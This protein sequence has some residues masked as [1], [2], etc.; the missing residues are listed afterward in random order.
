[1]RLERVSGHPLGKPTGWIEC[2][3]CVPF[4]P[5]SCPALSLATEQSGT[6]EKGSAAVIPSSCVCSPPS[7]AWPVQS[8]PMATGHH[9]PLTLQSS[10]AS[11][12]PSGSTG[13]EP[14]MAG[15]SSPCMLTWGKALWGAGMSLEKSKGAFL[16]LQGGILE[17]EK[18]LSAGTHSGQAA[19]SPGQDFCAGLGKGISWM[20]HLDHLKNHCQRY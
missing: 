15:Q 6:T 8:H 3:P 11:S 18:P 13:Q 17:K 9:S 16:C 10:T 7:P 4:G 12:V 19:L 2:K 14:G 5:W 1:M 20:S